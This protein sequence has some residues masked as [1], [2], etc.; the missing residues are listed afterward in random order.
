[1]DLDDLLSS[2]ASNDSSDEDR[3]DVEEREVEAIVPVTPV[4][5]VVTPVVTPKLWDFS[6]ILSH[7]STI[8]DDVIDAVPGVELREAWEVVTSKSW[9]PNLKVIN[10]I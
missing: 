10:N 7:P 4:A 1:M 9:T 2:S 6:N 8:L 3:D 5:P